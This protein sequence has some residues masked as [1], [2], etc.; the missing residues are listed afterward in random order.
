[1]IVR[2]VKLTFQ[3]GKADSF[4]EIFQKTKKHIRDMR[5]C[6]FLEL[7]QEK[8]DPNSFMTYSV[9]SSDEDLERYRNSDLFVETW[10]KIKG[11]FAKPAEARTMDR[12]EKT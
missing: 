11:M 4:I 12:I 1:M 10:G 5:G 8:G 2:I 9:W 7:L 6:I 3:E